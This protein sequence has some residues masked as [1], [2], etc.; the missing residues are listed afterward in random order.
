MTLKKK[1]VKKAEKPKRSF[2]TGKKSSKEKTEKPSRTKVADL[3]TVNLAAACRPD[4]IEEYVGQDAIQKT[5]RGW[6]KSGRVPATILIHGNLGAGKT[7]LARLIARYVNCETFSACGKCRSCQMG[8]NG[9]PDILQYDMGGESGKVDG[10]RAIVDSAHLSPMFKRRVFI[11]DE[12]HLMSS[13]A[14]SALLVVTEEPPEGTMW[15]MCTT[16]PEKMKPTIV[17]RS[18]TLAIQAIE[19]DVIAD[20]LVELA[21]REGFYPQDKKA[22]VEAKKALATIA[23]YSNGQMRTAIGMMQNLSDMIAGGEK[24]TSDTVMVGLNANHEVLLG[25]KA[26]S[27]AAAFCDMD[28]VSAI[29]FIR[30]AGDPRG[31]LHKTRWLLHGIIGHATNT[32]KFQTIELKKFLALAKKQKIKYALPQLIYLQRALAQVEL[33]INSASVPADVILESEVA[34]LMC[35]IYDGKVNVGE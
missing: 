5:F 31:I 17:S 21:K 13:Q 6:Q 34:G 26:V 27:L 33:T 12:S 28:L 15:I 32:N 4:S 19:E 10:I 29:Q 30:E 24:F 8:I 14:E 35:D 16:N 11:L 23:T 1:V 25:D 20:R 7:T 18:T 22:A 9:H 2:S 3:V